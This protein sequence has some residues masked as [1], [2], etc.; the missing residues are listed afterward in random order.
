MKFYAKY[1]NINMSRIGKQIITFDSS[2]DAQLKNGSLSIHGSMGSLSL[3]IPHNI[4]IEINDNFIKVAS[5]ASDKKSRSLWGLTRALIY[6][7]VIGVTTGHKKSLKII[8][9]GYKAILNKSNHLLLRLGYSHDIFY[10]GPQGIDI[11]CPKENQIDITGCDK[12][13]VGQVSAEIRNFRKPEPYKGKGIRY[14]DEFIA[15]KKG[16]ENKT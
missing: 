6:N 5:K 3:T 10:A 8:G 12:F 14:I 11:S 7:M 13:L 2:V 1:F 16:K 15:K 9:T 4:I